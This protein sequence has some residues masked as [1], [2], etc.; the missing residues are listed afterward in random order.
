MYY[1]FYQ[2][3]RLKS[4]RGPVRIFTGNQRRAEGLHNSLEKN[5]IPILPHTPIAR[6]VEII[7]RLISAET[8]ARAPTFATPISNEAPGIGIFVENEAVHVLPTLV[9]IPR[10]DAH[11]L[12]PKL[13]GDAHGRT[14]ADAPTDI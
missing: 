4:N 11:A 13:A 5:P 8:S 10:T 14:Q 12:Y 7:N 3:N 9:P 6:L 1:V 2:Q